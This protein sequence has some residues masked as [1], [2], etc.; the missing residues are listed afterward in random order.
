MFLNIIYIMLNSYKT[1]YNILYK[2]STKSNYPKM[3]YYQWHFYYYQH[4]K[5]Y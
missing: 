1:V 2:S 4:E 3:T 5:E